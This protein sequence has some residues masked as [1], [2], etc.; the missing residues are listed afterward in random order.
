MQRPTPSRMK[1]GTRTDGASKMRGEWMQRLHLQ[2]TSTTTT[3]GLRDGTTLMKLNPLHHRH[4]NNWSPQLRKRDSPQRPYTK[5]PIHCERRA[6]WVLK[7]LQ[8]WYRLPRT[9][10]M[11]VRSRWIPGESSY[12]P[13]QHRANVSHAVCLK[14]MVYPRQAPLSSFQPPPQFLTS[15]AHSTRFLAPLS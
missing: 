6:I 2:R 5:R 3:R 12:F 7:L 13:T 15:S 10:Y 9:S 4:L 8:P 14:T 11:K 1:M